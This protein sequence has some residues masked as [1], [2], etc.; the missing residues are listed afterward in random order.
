MLDGYQTTANN[1]W[2]AK[3]I[4]HVTEP[5]KKRASSKTASILSEHNVQQKF[6]APLFETI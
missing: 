4:Q 5:K 3:P 2:R 1:S 6:A